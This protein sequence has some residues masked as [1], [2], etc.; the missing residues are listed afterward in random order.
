ML[1]GMTPLVA[2][3]GAAGVPLRFII[4]ATVTAPVV[5]VTVIGA[6]DTTLDSPQAA[7][8]PPAAAVSAKCHRASKQQLTTIHTTRV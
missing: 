2:A 7:R 1:V 6:V 4:G 5:V 3:R 8:M